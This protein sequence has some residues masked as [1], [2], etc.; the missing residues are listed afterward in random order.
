MDHVRWNDHPELRR[1]VLVAAFEGWNDAADAASAAARFLT[2][3]WGARSFATIDPEEF[4]DFSS[5]RPEVR[6]N[7]DM[8][9]EIVWPTT[10]LSFARSPGGDHDVVFLMGTEPQL[11]WQTFCNTVISIARQLEVELIVT[12]GALLADVSHARPVRITG[13]AAD[14][15]LV[16]RLGL[17]RSTYEGPTGILG[18]LHDAAQKAGLQSASLWASVPHYVAAT[19]SPKATLALVQRATRLL[20]MSVVT[21]Q[22]EQEAIDY[23]RQVSEVV[24]SD[25]DVAAYVKHLEQEPDDDDDPM[26]LQSGEALAAELEEF[27]KQQRGD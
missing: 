6:L 18:V 27:L 15:D 1:P 13:T 25:D 16:R 17:A 20:S 4:F 11:K 7:D 26:E 22:L 2:A 9:R 3:R 24:A 21:S 14:P 12:L 23:E 10:E 8:T 19:P 5:T